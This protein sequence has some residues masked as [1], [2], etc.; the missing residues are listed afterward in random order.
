MKNTKLK[1]KVGYI[2]KITKNDIPFSKGYKSQFTGQIFEKSSK[3]TKKPATYIIKDLK[4]E[5]ILSQ[6]YENQLRK[7]SD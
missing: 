3:S 5:E 4:K 1:F 2:V 7:S 6:F